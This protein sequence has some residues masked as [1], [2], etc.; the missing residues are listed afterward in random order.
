[1]T[2]HNAVRYQRILRKVIDALL[3]IPFKEINPIIDELISYWVAQGLSV[4][5]PDLISSCEE[6]RLLVRE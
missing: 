1:M 6:V 2:Y 3:E 5:Y 4:E